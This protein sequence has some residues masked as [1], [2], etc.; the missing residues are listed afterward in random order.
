MAA[1]GRPAAASLTSDRFSKLLTRAGHNWFSIDYRLGGLARFADS[2]ADCAPRWRSFAAAPRF[3]IDPNRLVLL[4]EDSGAQLA[5][6]LAAERPAGVIGAVLIGGFYDLAAALFGRWRAWRS[7]SWPRA[8]PIDTHLA[9][10][11]AVARGSW[12]CRHGGAH[13]AGARATAMPSNRAQGTLPADR[14]RGGKPSQRELVAEAVELQA[15]GASW[16]ATVSGATARAHQP[17]AGGP[18]QKD[19]VYSPSD[20]SSKLD[21]FLP[22]TSSPCPAVIIVHGGGWEAGDKV[23]YVTP[24][25]EPLARAG[26]AWFSIDY[27]LTPAVTHEDQLA[28]LRQAIR[29]VRDQHARFNIDPERIILIGESASGQMVAQIADRGQRRSPA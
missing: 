24:L 12:R 26:L 7:E 10:A 11:A 21:A 14:S 9:E 28:D 4:G 25:F 15:R 19:I 27:R 2:L 20:R 5:A 3:G 6:L 17:L 1:D 8:S 23:T 13:R 16:L 22:R 29:F 18:L